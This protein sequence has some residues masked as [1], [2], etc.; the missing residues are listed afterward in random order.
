MDS[1]LRRRRDGGSVRRVPRFSLCSARNQC[2]GLDWRVHSLESRSIGRIRL[3]IE[4]F[5]VSGTLGAIPR[6]FTRYRWTVSALYCCGDSHSVGDVDHDKNNVILTALAWTC[7]SNVT[8]AQELGIKAGTTKFRHQ[9]YAQRPGTAAHHKSMKAGQ[10]SLL[11]HHA[12]G[13]QARKECEADRAQFCP[14]IKWVTAR[15]SV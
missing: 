14:D 10:E 15:P 3:P 9:A 2:L 6:N 4:E 8:I 1:S 12:F 11:T 7:A 5:E 13:K